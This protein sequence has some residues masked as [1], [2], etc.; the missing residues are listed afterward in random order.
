ML[1]TGSHIVQGLV[2]PLFL[3]HPHEEE[4]PQGHQKNG[5]GEPYVKRQVGLRVRN[6]RCE[7]N[8]EINYKLLYQHISERCIHLGVSNY[9]RVEWV[10]YTHFV[11]LSHGGERFSL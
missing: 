10:H 5:H 1:T 8:A 6:V 11:N 7:K 3:V 4:R 9:P 2:L